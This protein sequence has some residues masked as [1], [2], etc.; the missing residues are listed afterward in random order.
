MLTADER[1]RKHDGG[2]P[3]A[4]YRRRQ[5][6]AD[7]RGLDLAANYDEL[8]RFVTTKL[9][10]EFQAYGLD[11]STFLV[12]NISLPPQVEEALDKR[13]AMGVIGDLSRYTQY[14]AA[15]A[16]RAAA[17]NPAGGGGEGIGL[18]VGLAMGQKMAQAIGGA[19]GGPPALPGAG[20]RYYIGVGGANNTD[21]NRYD[22]R[23][24]FYSTPK[25]CAAASSPDLGI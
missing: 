4:T 5:P 13:S 1:V 10:G 21:S 17:E 19:G 18:G 3:P 25:T 9:H 22:L 12:E 20:P 15:G 6:Q 16:M 23:V 14:E 24:R 11:L 2:A 8:G 7:F